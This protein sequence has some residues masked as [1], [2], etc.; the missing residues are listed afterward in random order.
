MLFAYWL[1]TIY[2]ISI[3]EHFSI[4]MALWCHRCSTHVYG[5]VYNYLVPKENFLCTFHAFLP[6]CDYC[7]AC[8]LGGGGDIWLKRCFLHV[9]SLDFLFLIVASALGEKMLLS[10]NTFYHFIFGFRGNLN[11]VWMLELC[12]PVAWRKPTNH[13]WLP[14]FR[15]GATRLYWL[16]KRAKNIHCL[17][18]HI[19]I[20][21]FPLSTKLRVGRGK[22]SNWLECAPSKKSD[23]YSPYCICHIISPVTPACYFLLQWQ[24]GP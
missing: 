9:I 24:W 10:N 17:H 8:L 13:S 6:T 21:T 4:M 5:N 11:R 14:F 19:C 22:S 1:H 20:T 18:I 3:W 7:H 15:R 23:H 12:S 2:Y 16:R